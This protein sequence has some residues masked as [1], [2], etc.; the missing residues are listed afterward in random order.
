MASFLIA[1]MNVRKSNDPA[2]PDYGKPRYTMK[3]GLK[4]FIEETP[5]V[6]PDVPQRLPKM[7]VGQSLDTIGMYLSAPVEDVFKC[8]KEG[9]TAKLCTAFNAAAATSE[10]VSKA[11]LTAIYVP[12][13]STIGLWAK[14]YMYD[15]KKL[16][17]LYKKV[18][19]EDTRLSESIGSM[20]LPVY[21]MTKQKVEFF[22]V[23]KTDILKS[24]SGNKVVSHDNPR[25]WE[26]AM[27][28]T[29]NNLAYK[30][31][32][33]GSQVYFDGAMFHQPTT[34]HDLAAKTGGKDV[35]LVNIGVVPTNQKSIPDILNNSSAFQGLVS[36]MRKDIPEAK[37]AEELQ[38][39]S[40]V[41]GSA[42]HGFTQGGL[43]HV[44]NYLQDMQKLNSG[45]TFSQDRIITIVPLPTRPN[46]NPDI[47][48][49]PLEAF[50]ASPAAISKILAYSKRTLQDQDPQIRQLSIELLANQVRLG[51]MSPAE[52]LEAKTRIEVQTIKDSTVPAYLDSLMPHEN[53]PLPANTINVPASGQAAAIPVS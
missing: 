15:P 32:I 46:E 29:A 24:D 11:A 50:V 22:T 44:Q 38:K 27:A 25:L 26:V 42:V 13:K 53:D 23:E 39:L 3:E 28:A 52:Y 6:F 17:G 40:D 10:V 48:P 30:P 37:T 16:E 21:N 8:S 36:A 41:Y 43:S 20:H 51:K 18:L 2:S 49:G 47:K 34:H 31:Y 14:D 4:L 5:K 12:A 35:V 7:I 33:M 45:R 1:G 9:V 19:G